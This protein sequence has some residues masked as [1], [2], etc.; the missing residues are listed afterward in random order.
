MLVKFTI[1]GG[2]EPV[3]MQAREEVLE[4]RLRILRQHD[5]YG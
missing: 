4:D 1:D 5:P 3:T 2:S